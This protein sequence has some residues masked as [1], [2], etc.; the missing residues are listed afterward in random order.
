MKISVLT[1]PLGRNYGGLLQAYAL[2]VTLKK[3]G[4]KAETLNRR[5]GVPV[6]TQ[7]ESRLKLLIKNFLA[8]LGFKK[9][10][11]DKVNPYLH[12][13]CFRDQYISMSPLIDSDKKI[14]NY[15]SKNYFDALIVGSDQVWR[16]R[17]SP[18]LANFFLD[19]C[20]H[21]NLDSKRIAYAAS[22]GVDFEEF[23]K[24]D[25]DVCRP[26]ARK[27]DAVSVREDS[28]A[29]LIQGYFGLQSELVFDP[30]L[31]LEAS[32]YEYIIERDHIED[33]GCQ[34]GLL[35]YVLDM[36]DE[37]ENFVNRVSEVISEEPSFLM[38]QPNCTPG[39][40]R[41][42]SGIYPNVGA[43]LNSFK[44]A[45]FVVTDSFHGCVFSII[46]NVPFVIIGNESRGMARFESLLKQFDLDNR[47]FKA[48]DRFDEI[49]ALGTIDWERV[50]KLRNLGREKSI[51]F[52][53]ESLSF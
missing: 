6:K 13:E 12:L 36:D 30:T 31:L 19:F 7:A 41:E 20:D 50:N 21:L 44:T 35:A 16:P 22:F 49:T 46:F 25:I 43:W 18:K 53:K 14:K 38:S 27:F 10:R 32:D 9:F 26:L 5:K 11:K 45:K 52:L 3:L 1:Q 29:D 15:Y 51:Q 24:A 34:K 8:V 39:K 40:D 47:L 33:H 17:Y 48:G 2:Q 28:G 37:K 23:S 4:C 42:F